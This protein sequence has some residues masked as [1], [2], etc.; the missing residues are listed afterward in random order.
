MALDF[1]VRLELCV[2]WCGVTCCCLGSKKP[3][4]MRRPHSFYYT[5]ATF[6]RHTKWWRE[7]RDQDRKEERERESN[8]QPAV[9]G[10]WGNYTAKVFHLPPISFLTGLLSSYHY[11]WLRHLL[12][13]RERVPLKCNSWRPA[14]GFCMLYPQACSADLT[15][16]RQASLSFCGCISD[17][18]WVQKPSLVVAL[19]DVALEPSPS[20]GIHTH[21]CRRRRRLNHRRHQ[22]H[23]VY[24]GPPFVRR[25]ERARSS[26][27]KQQVRER[28]RGRVW[29]ESSVQRVFSEG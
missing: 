5:T 11:F 4:L 28:E 22:N 9:P 14:Y 15:L 8:K 23:I 25:R 10:G 13:E 19:W 7:D 20:F 29:R 1:V 3:L 17:E 2:C 6:I 24:H 18:I 27:G 16:L 21:Q 26:A 12:R